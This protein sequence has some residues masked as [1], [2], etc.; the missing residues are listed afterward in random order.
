MEN[1]KINTKILDKEQLKVGVV[2]RCVLSNKNV[3][4]E[5]VYKNDLDKDE[6]YALKMF[7]EKWGD[8][9]SISTQNPALIPINFL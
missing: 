3:L 8:Y 7:D 5:D 9:K 6:T 1:E 4:L 2:Y